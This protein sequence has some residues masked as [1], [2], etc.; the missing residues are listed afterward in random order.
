M[1]RIST[2]SFQEDP[3]LFLKMSPVIYYGGTTLIYSVCVIG[4]LFISDLGLVFNLISA[5]VLSML[6]FIWPGTFYLM[7][8]RRFGNP[9]DR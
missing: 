2:Y 4:G 9:E 8:E 1:A 7:A 5:V 3:T 6:N